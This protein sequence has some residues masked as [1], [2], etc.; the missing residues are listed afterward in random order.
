[1]EQPVEKRHRADGAGNACFKCGQ[2]GH[3]SRE[4][5]NAPA[6]GGGGGSRACFNCGEEGHL[7]RDCPSGGRG[8]R[9]G[10]GGGFGGRGGSFGGRG[11]RGGG[12]SSGPKTC[13]KCN[14][15]GHISRDCPSQ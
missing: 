10:R 14:Q 12:F 7:S 4:C 8:G 9:G 1:M 11:A 3:F 6:G 13:Y 2:E 15:E 5:P